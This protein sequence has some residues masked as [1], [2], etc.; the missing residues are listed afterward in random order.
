MGLGSSISSE[1]RAARLPPHSLASSRISFDST[2]SVFCASPCT[3]LVAAAP[4]PSASAPLLTR[5]LIPLHARA[6]VSMSSRRSALMSFLSRWRDRRNWLRVIRL[7]GSFYSPPAEPCTAQEQGGDEPERGRHAGRGRQRAGSERN[8][9]MAGVQERGAQSH[10]LALP[11]GRRGL[12]EERHD[13]RLGAAQADSQDER[14]R[15][16][17]RHAR[18]QREHE[19]GGAGKRERE[20]HHAPLIEPADEERHRQSNRE[21]GEGK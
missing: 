18:D 21:G 10:R 5:V 13:D 1:A 8:Q 2:S 9:G 16:E 11:A 7:M 20:A 15:E 17:Q 4:S 14:Q 6:M 3:F 19:V 12:V